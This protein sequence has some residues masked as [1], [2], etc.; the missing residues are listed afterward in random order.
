MDITFYELLRVSF[1]S[2]NHV[3]CLPQWLVLRAHSTSMSPDPMLYY[4]PV[5]CKTLTLLMGKVLQAF[6]E[7]V[8]KFTCGQ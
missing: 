4:Q 3:S 1:K 7:V 6:P 2:P 5:S 8:V